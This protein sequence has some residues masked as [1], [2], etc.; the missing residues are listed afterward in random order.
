MNPIEKAASILLG[1]VTS[2][3]FLGDVQAEDKSTVAERVLNGWER[4]SVTLVFIPGCTEPHMETLTIDRDA[5]T[6]THSVHPDGSPLHQTTTRSFV[7][8]D[9]GMDEITA[10][11]LRYY[12]A[13]V[14]QKSI[15][16]QLEALGSDKEAKEHLRRK[17]PPGVGGYSRELMRISVR[18]EGKPESINE[19][20][21]GG[22]E[23]LLKW[24]RAFWDR[25]SDKSI[26]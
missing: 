19:E 15:P 6:L 20:F 10:T 1:I 7:V 14:S 13:A 24:L 4:L 11:L 5:S 16:E 22:M 25:A 18:N 12:R 2:I 23:Q 8:D 17:H 21:E 3:L 9:E 26:R